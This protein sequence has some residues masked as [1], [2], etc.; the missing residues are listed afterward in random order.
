[1]KLQNQ[2]VRARLAMTRSGL[3]LFILVMAILVAIILPITSPPVREPRTSRARFE[4]S[5][6]VNAIE[7]YEADYGRLPLTDVTTNADVTCGI[8]PAE[9]Q[10]FQPVKGTRLIATNSDLIIVLMDFDLGANA[11]DRLNPK[12]IKY[13]NARMTRD[14]NSSGVSVVD[15]QFRDPWGNPYIISLDANQDGLVRDG[16]YAHSNLFA[17]RPPTSL[18]KTNGLY[19]LRGKVMVWS[20]GPDGKASMSVPANRGVNKDN[21]VSWE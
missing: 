11:G 17:N 5:C 12:Q 21:A 14:V 19:E 10:D 15:H 6:L 16:F 18:T 20:R 1:M 9:I 3:L 8:S 2:T 13:L 7:A 4:V